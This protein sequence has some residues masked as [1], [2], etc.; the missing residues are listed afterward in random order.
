MIALIILSLSAA[1]SASD[2]VSTRADDTRLTWYERADC[3]TLENADPP[4]DF[5]GV[6]GGRGIC[7]LVPGTQLAGGASSYTVLCDGSAPSGTLS[8]YSDRNCANA[9]TLLSRPVIDEVCYANP[10]QFGS[11]AVMAQCNNAYMPPAEPPSGRATILWASNAAC[12]TITPRVLVDIRQT[13][14]QTVPASSPGGYKVTCSADGSIAAFDSYTDNS[15]AV[16]VNRR[17]LTRDVCEANPQEFGATNIA[18]R[19]STYVRVH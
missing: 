14:C 18:I 5:T 19:C 16:L 7:Q 17:F 3:R 9:M 13:F 6:V 4:E 12:D 2:F 1:A 10:P 15:C 11:S 8:F